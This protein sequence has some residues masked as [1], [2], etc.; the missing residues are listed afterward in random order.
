MLAAHNLKL[1]I[2]NNNSKVEYIMHMQLTRSRFQYIPPT[3]TLIRRGITVCY[4]GK[5]KKE[6]LRCVFI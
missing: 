1:T 2:L 3:T 5:L 4:Q 6:Y